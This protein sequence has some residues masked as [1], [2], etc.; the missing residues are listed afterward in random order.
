MTQP[1]P[2]TK[3][4]LGVPRGFVSSLLWAHQVSN[5][6]PPPCECVAGGLLGLRPFP[7]LSDCVGLRPRSGTSDSTESGRFGSFLK[8]SST[9]RAQ[10]GAFGGLS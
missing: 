7:F 2:E 4:P 5:L 9:N 10:A 6:G 3:K 8:F 1:M